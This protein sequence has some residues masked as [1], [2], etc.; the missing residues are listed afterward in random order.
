MGLQNSSRGQEEPRSTAGRDQMCHLNPH[1]A[2]S[3]CHVPGDSCQGTKQRPRQCPHLLGSG[4]S[5]TDRR[6]TNC[7]KPKLRISI[8]QRR[9]FRSASPGFLALRLGQ[10]GPREGRG[11]P[12]G[13]EQRASLG[14]LVPGP[15][16]SG[17]PA[18]SSEA[19]P[20]QRQAGLEAS[21]EH[22]WATA[23]EATR[24]GFSKSLLSL[25]LPS[26]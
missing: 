19:A 21:C 12:T 11:V 7:R 3:G 2:T 20:S 14:H 15:K 25:L 26:F 16:S 22:T 23:R 9:A 18:D 1:T 17:F 8:N 13:T 4:N 6:I 24:T 5:A 10:L